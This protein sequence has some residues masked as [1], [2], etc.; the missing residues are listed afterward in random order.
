MDKKK[1]TLSGGKKVLLILGIILGVIV[2]ALAAFMLFWRPI[3]TVYKANLYE[4]ELKTAVTGEVVF[5]GDSITDAYKLAE[6]YPRYT[7]YNRGISGD[8]TYHVLNRMDAV[9]KL[10]PSVVVLLIGTNDFMNESRPVDD[11]ITDYEKILLALR[12]NCPD[13][14]VICQSVYPGSGKMEAWQ[15][16]VIELN[17]RIAE[18]AG[19]YGFAY[20]DVYSILVEEG[21]LGINPAYSKD[22]VHPNDE[23][24]ALITQYL[25]PYLEEAYVKHT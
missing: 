3:Y 12:E 2:L 6:H 20:A 19:E 23:G 14:A 17:A 22:G 7:T 8:A 4:K 9:Y 1:K 18:L 10:Q 15:Q 21:G 5:L 25:T 16:G 13:A 24:Y 11:I